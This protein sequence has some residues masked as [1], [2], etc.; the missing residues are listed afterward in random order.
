MTDGRKRKKSG[1]V[2]GH[3]E[4]ISSK[5]FED[6][7]KLM[8]NLVKSKH[9]VYALYK[10]DRLYYIGLATNLRR[11]VKHHLRDRHAN[12]WDRF[13]LYLVKKADHIKDLESLV[14]R[15]AEPRGNRVKGKLV[16]STDL[17]P[18]L[19]RGLIDDRKMEIDRILG[20]KPGKKNKT[21]RLSNAKF[22]FKSIE[23]ILNP[24]AKLIGKYKGKIYKAVVRSKGKI[25]LNGKLFDSPSGAAK[26]IVKRAANG[27]Y[28]WKYR[29][30]D[31][32]WKRLKEFRK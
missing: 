6:Y 32:D 30:K 3:L 11:R 21:K 15:I 26:S 31:R 16:G 24:N 25:E 4:R 22:Q 23:G 17:A 12:K 14:V 7:L 8:T 10:K 13:S 9:G 5:A 27:W 1:L 19:K 28:F 18:E 2:E 20:I 29:D